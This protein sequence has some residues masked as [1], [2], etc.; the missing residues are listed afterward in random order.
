MLDR[1]LMF[2][3][4]AEVAL[5][6]PNSIRD[7]S[8]QV[9][10]RPYFDLDSRRSPD[11]EPFLLQFLR[12][13]FTPFIWLYDQMESVPDALR[14]VIVGICVLLCVAL[15]AHIAYTLLKAIQGPSARRRMAFNS[16]TKREVEPREFEE[17]AELAQKNHDYIGAVRLL[18]RGALRRIELYEK[19]KFRPGIT[20]REL[21]RRYRS[22]PLADSMMRFVNT[23]EFKWYGQSPC[24][25]TDFIAC[26]NEHGRICQYIRESK[27]AD[28]S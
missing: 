19:K 5:P 7:A 13:L 21:L 14:W 4:L 1:P 11:G 24:E 27:P 2:S 9:L 28:R 12:W 8:R 20:N 18:F 15:I 3:S 26:R 16:T 23:I 10:D 25:Q 6:P 22:T 17:Q